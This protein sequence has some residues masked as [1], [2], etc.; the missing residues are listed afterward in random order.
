VS[1]HGIAVGVIAAVN[2]QVTCTVRV[3]TGYTTQADG[4]R[5]PQY[6]DLLNVPAQIQALSY[7]DIQLLD[8]LQIQ[9]ERRGIYLTG[10]FDSLNR[11]P[12]TGGDLIV[13][14]DGTSWPFGTVWKIAYVLEQ[15]PDWC[16]VAATRMIPGE[17]TS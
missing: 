2:P 13:F 15:W 4:T 1:L 8:G 14:P 9:G 11:G 17:V 5:V 16:H 7:G 3:S 12:Q 6:S 10:N